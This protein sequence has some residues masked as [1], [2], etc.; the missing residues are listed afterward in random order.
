M[1]KMVVSQS[2]AKFDAM[3]AMGTTVIIGVRV[4]GKVRGDVWS[5]RPMPRKRTLDR[6]RGAPGSGKSTGGEDGERSL[7]TSPGGSSTS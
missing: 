4:N 6:D 2:L 5:L 3:L 1:V 7:S